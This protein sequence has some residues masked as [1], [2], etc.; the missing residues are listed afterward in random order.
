MQ[1]FIIQ[2]S[3]GQAVGA[4]TLNPAK[5]IATNLFI[6][7]D[8]REKGYGLSVIGAFED[9]ARKSNWHELKAHV[10]A[11]RQDTLDLLE[12]RGWVKSGPYTSKIQE[13]QFY[14]VK[15]IIGSER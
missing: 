10:P 12:K 9:Y 15:K 3:N 1:Y 7:P 13:K 8:E 11:D 2:N 14:I 4:I 5:K 6:L